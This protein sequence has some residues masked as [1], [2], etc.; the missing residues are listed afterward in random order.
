MAHVTGGVLNFSSGLLLQ[1]SLEG[2][3]GLAGLVFGLRA[4]VVVVASDGCV[5]L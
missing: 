2:C 1:G 3:V 5:Q 4:F